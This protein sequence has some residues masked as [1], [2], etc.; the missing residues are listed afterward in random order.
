MG[1][2]Y[3]GGADDELLM[4]I[5]PRFLPKV[6]SNRRPHRIVR[7]RYVG[8]PLEAPMKTPLSEDQQLNKTSLRLAAEKWF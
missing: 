7:S 2:D 5:P 1:G 6:I 4:A 3:G 8:E